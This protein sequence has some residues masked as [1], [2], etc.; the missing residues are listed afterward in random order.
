MRAGT[1]GGTAGTLALWVA[2]DACRT[3]R[4]AQGCIV[5]ALEGRVWMTVEGDGEDYWLEPGEGLPLA[6]GERARIGGWREA[7]R[8]EVQPL[9][10]PPDW[11]FARLCVWVRSRLARRT[12]RRLAGARARA[13]Q[14]RMA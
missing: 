5:M 3:I 14:E 11:R 7:V 13:P 9:A 8:F 6:P 10:S 2:R 4:P 1:R 12:S